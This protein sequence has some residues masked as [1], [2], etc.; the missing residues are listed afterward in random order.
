[1]DFRLIFSCGF[2]FSVGVVEVISVVGVVTVGVIG[3]IGMVGV[4]DVIGVVAVVVSVAGVPVG[5]MSGRVSRGG[6]E[7]STQRYPVEREV[8]SSEK[9]KPHLF[10]SETDFDHLV[11][12]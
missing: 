10:M 11:G 4:V 8:D 1:M 12:E 9:Q 6:E 7:E 3:M 2:D 5:V